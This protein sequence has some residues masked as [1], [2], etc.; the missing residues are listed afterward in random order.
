ML[1]T[2]MFKDTLKA[3]HDFKNKQKRVWDNVFW[4]VKVC[5]F[6]KCIQYTIHW[7]ETQML[8]KFPSDKINIQNMSSF[9]FRKPQPITVLLLICDSYMSWSLRFV[10]L[11][12]V[13]LSQLS[14]AFIKV[15]IFVQQNAWTYLL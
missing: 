14:F 1:C 11:K 12:L 15:Y 6:W 10:S 13:L 9:F 8:N 2:L 5:I 7:D 4:S 3:F